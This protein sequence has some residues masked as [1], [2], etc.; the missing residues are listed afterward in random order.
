MI[1]FSD[2]STLLILE[3]FKEISER[4]SPSPESAQ[5]NFSLQAC[6][7]VGLDVEK[8]DSNQND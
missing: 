3:D 8:L 2:G 6:S 5:V 1:P 4:Q 7:K